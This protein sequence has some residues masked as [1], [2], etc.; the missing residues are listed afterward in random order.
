MIYVIIIVVILLIVATI[1]WILTIDRRRF[2][3]MY[4][5]ELP[6]ISW[7]TLTSEPDKIIKGYTRYRFITSAG[8]K[9]LRY[10]LNFKIIYPTVIVL[11]RYK[12]RIWHKEKANAFYNNIYHYMDLPLNYF[13]YQGEVEGDFM[14]FFRRSQRRF[15]IY[16]ASL[17]NFIGYKTV[18]TKKKMVPIVI[19]EN[20]G[21]MYAFHV[22][23]VE[24]QIVLNDMARFDRAQDGGQRVFITSSS[25]TSGAR[26]YAIAHNIYMMDLDCLRRTKLYEDLK[27]L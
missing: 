7:V 26:G 1:L 12:I 19:V 6:V 21:K 16:C 4:K 5:T 2:V 9:D 10:A 20:S 22:A 15:V 11:N 23:L 14:D 25:F 3:K 13:G 18:L 24:R 17:F 8:K 27:F